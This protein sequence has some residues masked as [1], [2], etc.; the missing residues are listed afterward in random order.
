MENNNELFRALGKIEGKIDGMSTQLLS[1][2]GRISKIREDVEQLQKKLNAAETAL[3]TSKAWIATLAAI[4][5]GASGTITGYVR[6]LL[7]VAP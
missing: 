2:D 5:G 1:Y 7:G 4:I 6:H 3:K